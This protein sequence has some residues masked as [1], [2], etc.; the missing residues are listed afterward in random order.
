MHIHPLPIF[1][2][3][4][5]TGVFVYIIILHIILCLMCMCVKRLTFV[6]QQKK[7]IL[8][9]FLI[10]LKHLGTTCGLSRQERG[11]LS[12]KSFTQHNTI[13]YCKFH[14]C[15]DNQQ[16]VLSPISHLKQFLTLTN[17]KDIHIQTYTQFLTQN[18]YAQRK[19]ILLMRLL[20][21]YI[22]RCLVD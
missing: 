17:T 18:S 14:M 5:Y 21:K 12:R 10:D 16:T 7:W 1:A 2:R 3:I 20:I 13:T 22:I 9:T 19:P 6:Q 15:C 11:C 4:G 8:T